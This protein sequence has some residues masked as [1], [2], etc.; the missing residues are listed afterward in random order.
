MSRRRLLLRNVNLKRRLARVIKQMNDASVTFVLESRDLRSAVLTWQAKAAHS[1]AQAMSLADM[2][3]QL[4]VKSAEVQ[5]L[6]LQILA[7]KDLSFPT[8]P[9]TA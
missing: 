2:E 6:R 9:L 1:E 3:G 4:A 7:D 8:H 5:S